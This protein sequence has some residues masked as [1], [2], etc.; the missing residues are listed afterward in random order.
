ME[1]NPRKGSNKINREIGLDALQ[2]RKPPNSIRP[3]TEK[4]NPEKQK[5]KSIHL[6]NKVCGEFFFS[7]FP[8]C[9]LLVLLLFFLFCLL[10]ICVFVILM[11]VH[12]TCPE[13]TLRQQ[14]HEQHNCSNN[15]NKKANTYS[16][17]NSTHNNYN[18]NNNMSSVVSTLY[19]HA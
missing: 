13:A 14:Q 2:T 9:L 1:T 16:N 18:N 11:S 8:F 4:R 19:R 15:N 5:H 6:F 10:L 17:N 3:A 12:L 7:C